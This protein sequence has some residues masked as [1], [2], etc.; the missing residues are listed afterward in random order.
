MPELFRILPNLVAL[1]ANSRDRNWMRLGVGLTFWL[2]I[3]LT[4][5]LIALHLGAWPREYSTSGPFAAETNPPRASLILQVPEQEPAS[6]W[7][8]PLVGD[9]MS[10]PFESLLG[11][12]IDGREMGP[13]HSPHET[14]RSGNTGAFSHWGS[15]IIFS[16]P[17]DVNNSPETVATLHYDLRPRAWVTSVVA[18]L[19][20]VLGFLLYPEELRWLADRFVVRLLLRAPY[21]ALSALFCLG[22]LASA[23]YVASILYALAAGWA[24]PTTFLI[25]WSSVADWAARNEPY[26]GHL[27]LMLAGL[28]TATAWLANISARH[29]LLADSNERSS[30][31]LF[32][33]CGFPI[34]ACALVVCTSAMW[35][36]LVRPGDLDSLSI[37]GLIPFSDAVYYL[38]GSFDQVRDG[39][40]NDISLRRPLASAFRTILLVLGNFSL[41][42]VLILQACLLAAALCFATYAIAKWR[43][44]WAGLTFFALVYIFDRILAPTILTE[45]FG[46]FWALL[47]IPFFIEAFRSHS[48]RPALVAFAMTTVALMTRMG[49]MFT[50]PLLIV[51]MAWQFGHNAVAKLRILVASVCILL[52]VFGASSMLQRIYGTGSSPSTGNFSYVLCG[53][54]M[55]TTWDGCL[56]RLAE[57]G[58]PVQGS[59]DAIARQLYAAAWRNLRADPGP[60]FHRLEDGVET[61]VTEYPSVFWKGYTRAI[62]LPDWMLPNAIAALS[63]VGFLYGATRRGNAVEL[64]FWLL[65]WLGIVASSSI[66]YLEDGSRV[67]AASHPLMAL[68]FASG[69]SAFVSSSA[70]VP[71]QSRLSLYGCAGLIAA[72]LLF[73][74]I[75]WMAHRFST[76]AVN[77][78]PAETPNEAL[79]W[80]GRRMSGFLVIANDQPLPHDVPALHLSS[81]EAIIKQSS[82][83]TYQELIHP[84]PPPLP[85]GFVFAPRLERGTTIALLFLVP[86][87]VLERGDVPVW[88]FDYEPWGVRHNPFVY[89]FHVTRAAP[90]HPARR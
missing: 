56:K 87:Q 25:R 75:P 40:W 89:W 23:A 7:R 66:I 44:I 63:L 20:A 27:L 36:G 11:L 88:H 77:A 26:F 5:V 69:M 67:L 57:E 71:S 54:S 46:I 85:F 59:E 28:G 19:T 2:L 62:D 24:L 39:I 73:V 41:Q 80:G 74:C 83:E 34:A 9:S 64:T 18:L 21:L 33:C 61:F 45:P 55:G 81:F 29:R 68:F 4:L 16:L 43:G 48:V 15:S 12:R 78:V 3:A 13:A 72:G 58:T 32:A 22:A 70:R 17:P 51:W 49:S 84:A 65:L 38:A 50:L 30:L 10:K 60:F 52:A 31:W 90:Y 82:I 35:S 86:A 53:L 14:I 79:V 76:A 1:R 6:W 37:G 42:S 8:R 47:S